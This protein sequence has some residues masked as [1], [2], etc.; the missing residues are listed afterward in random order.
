MEI[1]YQE[2]LNYSNIINEVINAEIP[3][4]AG[5][6]RIEEVYEKIKSEFKTFF[7]RKDELYKE[8][9]IIEERTGIVQKF[10]D[11]S[12]IEEF[13]Y[14]LNE[15]MLMTREI[16][17]NDY[18]IKRSYLKDIKLLLKNEK[19][20]IIDKIFMPPMYR[21]IMKKFIENDIKE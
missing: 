9:F 15:L 2:I 19:G 5:S 20:V 18:K 12:K 13:N 21:I 4:Y 1:T 10:K 14:K 3:S 16:D 6:C 17:I 7:G 11:E 8:Y